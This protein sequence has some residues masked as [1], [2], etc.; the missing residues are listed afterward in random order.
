METTHTS[1][2]NMTLLDTI[3]VEGARKDVSVAHKIGFKY[4][5]SILGD[6][7]D[8][9]NGDIVIRRRHRSG[10][11]VLFSD[12]QAMGHGIAKIKDIYKTWRRKSWSIVHGGVDPTDIDL[13]DEFE[14]FKT[15]AQMICMPI[16]AGGKVTYQELVAEG[17]T[18]ELIGLIFN[19]CRRKRADLV[20]GS[21]RY[22]IYTEF[23]KIAEKW[24][25]D[26]Y[27]NGSAATKFPQYL[28]D[29][30]KTQRSA[31]RTS[32]C[33]LVGRIMTLTRR[34]HRGVAKVRHDFRTQQIKQQQ[35]TAWN[36]QSM[37]R[38]A[39]KQKMGT[40]A[41][42]AKKHRDKDASAVRKAAEISSKP[43]RVSAFLEY[44]RSAEGQSYDNKM[45]AAVLNRP[46][47]MS[48][49]H[50]PRSLGF[51]SRSNL[52]DFIRKNISKLGDMK[53]RFDV[54]PCNV[55]TVLFQSVAV[56]GEGV[57]Q[58][59]NTNDFDVNGKTFSITAWHVDSR[60]DVYVNLDNRRITCHRKLPK[61]WASFERWSDYGVVGNPQVAVSMDTLIKIVPYNI[62]FFSFSKDN[63]MYAVGHTDMSGMQ[64]SVSV[65]ES[66]IKDKYMKAMDEARADAA[67][68]R[69]RRAKAARAAEMGRNK[70]NKFPTANEMSN[71][72]LK[73]MLARQLAEGSIDMEAFKMGMAALG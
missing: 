73:A 30:S 33:S 56:A 22:D 23:M 52:S 55:R 67:K 8:F 51:T 19:D 13:A 49:I 48:S 18:S 26:S 3:R 36:K 57:L 2:R 12:L 32:F 28:E 47:H 31:V 61:E 11:S 38:E 37:K 66:G 72:S 10:A 24:D 25:V 5:I 50:K 43:D 40:D 69:D 21:L 54:D 65:L 44:R 62:S 70:C 17:K 35:E 60:G 15:N 42:N 53:I 39:L 45:V 6:I 71:G 34:S 41:F 59:S 4:A 1:P 46:K 14:A 29:H 63:A 58:L 9:K 20:E 68:V 64:K 7:E 16:L 27:A